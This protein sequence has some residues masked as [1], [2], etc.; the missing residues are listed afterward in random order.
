MPGTCTTP[1]RSDWH[2]QS[3]LSFF[4]FC[5]RFRS[6]NKHLIFL[7]LFEIKQHGNDYAILA[8]MGSFCDVRMR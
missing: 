4:L 8:S 6:L 5:A 1:F 3:F 7:I 2:K